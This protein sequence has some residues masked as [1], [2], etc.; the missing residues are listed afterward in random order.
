MYIS[1]IIFFFKVN[2][3]I[4]H[5]FCGSSHWPDGPVKVQF[6]ILFRQFVGCSHKHHSVQELV[7]GVLFF[8][9]IFECFLNIQYV[10]S[11]THCQWVVQTMFFHRHG[12][13]AATLLG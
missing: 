2:E 6:T 11:K 1:H 4:L 7:I 3:R 13:A 8:S 12:A 10:L 9:W 5:I